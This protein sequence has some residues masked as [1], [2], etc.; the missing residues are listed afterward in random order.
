MK[1]IF[2]AVILVLAFFSVPLTL[3]ANEI[4]VSRSFPP[5]EILI[6]NVN[7]TPFTHVNRVAGKIALDNSCYEV[8]FQSL[9]PQGFQDLS[10]SLTNLFFCRLDNNKWTYSRNLRGDTYFVIK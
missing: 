5:D 9:S 4:Y 3:Q 7:A 10:R 2:L 8:F 6:K 1:N